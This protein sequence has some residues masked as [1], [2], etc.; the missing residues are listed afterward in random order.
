MVKEPGPG[1][2][3]GQRKPTLAARI[4][5]LAMALPPGSVLPGPA[6]L[7][8]DL[9]VREATVY[10]VRSALTERG[11]LLYTPDAGWGLS[12][13]QRLRGQQ[14]VTRT[15]SGH[16]LFSL[17]VAKR[18]HYF[19]V[20]VTQR[21]EVAVFPAN[22]GGQYWDPGAVV[23]DRAQDCLAVAEGSFT[24]IRD[25]AAAMER[26]NSIRAQTLG[27]LLRRSPSA[28]TITVCLAGP[29]ESV[30]GWFAYWEGGRSGGFAVVRHVRAGD[31]DDRRELILVQ[32]TDPRR[33]PLDT[34]PFALPTSDWKWLT[35]ID[36]GYFPG[37]ER[38]IGQAVGH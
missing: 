6:E 22:A 5:E 19:V 21:R 34:P 4:L 23:S 26:G 11:D 15:V 38:A 12:P 2:E 32:G 29:L 17:P 9:D 35:E 10:Q 36:R 30:P 37:I 13:Q 25:A 20:D 28:R 1:K 27:A 18:V 16:W 24:A 31:D 8:G 14:S 7:A 33:V 3:P